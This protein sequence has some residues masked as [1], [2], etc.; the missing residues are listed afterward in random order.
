[1]TPCPPVRTLVSILGDTPMVLSAGPACPFPSPGRCVWAGQI[2]VLF[3]TTPT[4]RFLLFFAKPFFFNDFFFS[5]AGLL[6]HDQT[7]HSWV[8]ELGQP[9]PCGFYLFFSFPLFAVALANP[10]VFHWRRNPHFF[11]PGRCFFSRVPLLGPQFPPEAPFF[12]VR[13]YLAGFG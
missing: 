8:Q 7:F 1:L 12:V 5:P 4:F 13:R 2:G 6:F 3:S 10:P 9:L 11:F